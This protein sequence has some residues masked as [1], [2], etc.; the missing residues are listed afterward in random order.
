MKRY[1]RVLAI[2]SLAMVS[3]MTGSLNA[4][5]TTTG[6]TVIEVQSLFEYPVAPETLPDITSKSN[7]L[8]ENFW[9]KFDFSQ[10]SV[11][12]VALNHAMGVYTTPMRWADQAVVDKSLA[13]LFKK[14]SKSPT[15]LYQFT[16]AAEETI[17]SEDADVWIDEVYMKFLDAMLANKKISD[18]RK[19][20]YKAQRLALGNSLK[21]KVLP[22]FK[23]VSVENYPREFETVAPLTLLEFGSPSCTDCRMTK[24]KLD[25]NSRISKMVEQGKLDIYFIVPDADSE[26]CWQTQLAEYPKDWHVGAGEGLDEL[27]DLR[28]TPS[29]YLLTSDGV[30]IEK[31]CPVEEMIYIIEE[32]SNN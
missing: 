5:D 16:K 1:N 17:Y 2:S 24:L 31:N 18:V 13:T 9:S 10:K 28:M 6:R 14:L 7:Y 22:H 32:K 27:Y 15:L 30:I 11:A 21:G 19:A 12:Q 26:D 25:T 20:K 3:L 29:L 23:Y 4:Q 8:V